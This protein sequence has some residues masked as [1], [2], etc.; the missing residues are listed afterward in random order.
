MN[1]WLSVTDILI[2][3]LIASLL[4]STHCVGMCGPFVL[5]ATQQNV[6]AGS[7][8]W[9]LLTRLNAYHFGRL[10]T[11]IV[12][13][14]LVGLASSWIRASGVI[15]NVG[16][17]VGVGMMLVGF[18][19]LLRLWLPFSARFAQQK[20]IAPMHA[21]WVEA[22]SRLIASA[23]RHAPIRSP[24]G[25]AYVWGVTST[26]LPCGWLYFFL[27]FAIALGHSLGLAVCR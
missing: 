6:S 20:K 23:R 16:L 11:Y 27:Y 12:L 14:C 4:G 8:R 22:W 2:G 18:I 5:L 10:T 15:T 13:G 7:D 3:T 17:F 21:K 24:L 19:Q 1:T 25:I 26:L 9:G